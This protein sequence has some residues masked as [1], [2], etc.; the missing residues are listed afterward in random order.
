MLKERVDIKKNKFKPVAVNEIRSELFTNENPILQ[1]I[2][3]IA[4]F[5][6]IEEVYCMFFRCSQKQ[7]KIMEELQKR[8]RLPIVRLLLSDSIPYMVKSTSNYLKDNA[9][10]KTS[11]IN[12]HAK[13]SG[14][15]T[16]KNHYF[17]HSS[18][19][20]NSDGKIE[21]LTIINSKHIY[22]SH[23]AFVD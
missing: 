16:K 11:Y 6:K 10:F 5:D 19:N 23:K 20:T 1:A 9:N 21:S 8:D 3:D 2:I 14:I 13:F 15:K 12:T 7:L 17:I 4:Y 22:E 18:A